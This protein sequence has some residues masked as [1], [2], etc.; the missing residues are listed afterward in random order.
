MDAELKSSS[1]DGRYQVRIVAWEAFNSQWVESPSIIDTATGN[2][3]LHV[4]CNL[5]SL[6]R[7]VWLSP[8]RVQL[9]LRKYPGNHRP[10]QIMVTIDCSA[11]TATLEFA[12]ALE[13][14]DIVTLDKLEAVLERQL[15]WLK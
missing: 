10:V 15:V 12:E 2:N 5:W 6:D 8:T 7:S 13:S 14:A 9:T 3:L 11:Q 4:T 1:A